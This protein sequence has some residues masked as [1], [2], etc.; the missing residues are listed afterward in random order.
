MLETIQVRHRRRALKQLGAAGAAV[1]VFG[2]VGYAAIG[3]THFPRETRYGG[4]ACGEV[5]E[6]LP[7]YQAKRLS[8]ELSHKVTLHLRQ[9]PDC[10]PT[11]RS[12]GGRVSI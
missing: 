8:A 5:M 2:I 3:R 1:V 12:A 10:G 4:L 9:C 6:L 11:F 7:D